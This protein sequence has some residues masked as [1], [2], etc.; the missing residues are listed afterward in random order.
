MTGNVYSR[1]P[2]VIIIIIIIRRLTTRAMSKY[3]TESDARSVA[4][5]DV[6]SC[7]RMVHKTKQ[8]G[9]E[10]VVESLHSWSISYMAAGISVI[11]AAT[12]TKHL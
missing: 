8:V 1:R 5:W 6:G 4:K 7:L 9:F 2:S 11:Q 10:P 3:M 12:N